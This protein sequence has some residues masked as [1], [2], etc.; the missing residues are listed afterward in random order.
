[1]TNSRKNSSP[2]HWKEIPV[3][4]SEDSTFERTN[5]LRLAK[6]TFL[7]ADPQPGMFILQRLTSEKQVQERYPCLGKPNRRS[8]HWP[9]GQMRDD[10]EGDT[11][12]WSSAVRST[13]RSNKD[14][15]P[16]NVNRRTEY[17]G[18][19]RSRLR[20]GDDGVRRKWGAMRRS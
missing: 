7:F 3:S 18:T 13:T 1:M 19:L 12:G 17:A 10:A 20:G 8:R 9:D 5:A 14:G 6:P 15:I 16:S 4:R 2:K 11:H